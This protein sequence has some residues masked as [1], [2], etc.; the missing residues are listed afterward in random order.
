MKN[1]SVCPPVFHF[2]NADTL[3]GNQSIIS[4]QPKRKKSQILAIV[5]RGGICTI[6]LDPSPTSGTCGFPKDKKLTKLIFGALK[7]EDTFSANRW[8]VGK[9]QQDGRASASL[10]QDHGRPPVRPGGGNPAVLP[11]EAHLPGVLQEVSLKRL[12]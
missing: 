4:G 5:L 1:Y 7:I 8:L 6:Y 12:H 3:R 9:Q 11:Q 10:A 2:R